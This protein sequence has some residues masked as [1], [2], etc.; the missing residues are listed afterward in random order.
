M[1]A[2]IADD[3]ERLWNTVHELL[4][5]A[6][7]ETDGRGTVRVTLDLPKAWVVLAAWMQTKE[8]QHRAGRYTDSGFPFPEEA[9]DFINAEV[10]RRARTFLEQRLDWELLRD[11]QDLG[12][13]AHPLWRTRAQG[14][15]RE[16]DAHDPAARQARA[17]V[18]RPEEFAAVAERYN[19]AVW[20]GDEAQAIYWREVFAEIVL[21]F[22]E[23]FRRCANGIEADMLERSVSY[24]GG[25][26]DPCAEEM[27]ALEAA[28]QQSRGDK[29]RRITQDEGEFAE[30]I[31][32]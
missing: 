28:E 31:P 20:R 29:R 12:A 30:A 23:E 10:R 25:E 5:R 6:V 7:E 32:F 11:L 13:R 19:R 8:E 9:P 15:R 21:I 2:E 24:S 4:E 17:L 16:A 3:V 22:D 27:A 14:F 1:Q 26:Y 18:D